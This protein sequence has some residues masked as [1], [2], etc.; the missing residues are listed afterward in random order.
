MLNKAK[1]RHIIFFAI[2]SLINC[3]NIVKQFMLLETI[4]FLQQNNVCTFT[5]KSFGNQKILHLLLFVQLA[6][7]R[8]CSFRTN[9]VGTVNS[10]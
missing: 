9:Y 4:S 8:L 5:T 1:N 7:H 10:K 2:T 6:K 3:Y